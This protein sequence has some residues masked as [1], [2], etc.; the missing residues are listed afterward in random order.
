[1]LNSYT[2][3]SVRYRENDVYIEIVSE[4]TNKDRREALFY[5]QIADT[6]LNIFEAV[7]V[8]GDVDAADQLISLGFNV[9]RLNRF[10]EN[11][12][13]MFARS[14][15]EILVNKVSAIAQYLE[16]KGVDVHQ[17]NLLGISGRD[18]LYL[19]HGVVI[20]EKEEYW[21]EENGIRKVRGFE[22]PVLVQM[23][24]MGKLLRYRT[25]EEVRD[26]RVWHGEAN[27]LNIRD[28]LFGFVKTA[29]YSLLMR[30]LDYLAWYEGSQPEGDI[31][32]VLDLH[33]KSETLISYVLKVRPADGQ[34]IVGLLLRCGASPFVRVD[35]IEMEVRLQ[36]RIKDLY[37][38]EL[39]LGSRQWARYVLVRREQE[40][41]QQH[42][43]QG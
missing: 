36:A 9:N 39:G 14:K 25:F 7:L 40:S 31:S 10:G 23:T 30:L 11:T 17:R 18:M 35:G 15:L 24:F 32:T 27:I 42:S 1:M 12:Y 34:P 41:I 13:F 37:N 21:K 20:G 5:T 26:S 16:S 3:P 8:D 28:Y 38:A 29:Q 19:K 6:G 4:Q 2:P 33:F 43:L 22:Y